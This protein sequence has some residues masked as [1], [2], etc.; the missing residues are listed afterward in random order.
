[1]ANDLE[2][3]FYNNSGRLIHKWKHY[4][5]VYDTYFS[6]F[7]NRE[8]VIVEIGV[9]Q[10]GSLQM[11]KSY[12]GEQASIYGI[13]I[14]PNCKRFEEQNIKIFIGS[15]S[16]RKF[17]RSLKSKIPKIDILI[18]DGGHSMEQQKIAFEELYSHIK[19]KGIYL[20]EDVHTSYWIEFGGGYKRR[21]TFIE[22]SKILI[23]QLNAFHSR[24]SLFKIDEFTKT[25]KA[26]HFYDS[27]VVIEKLDR[28]EPT[29]MKTGLPDTNND[30]TVKKESRLY[31]GFLY[32]I[33]IFL[34]FIGL[35]GYKWK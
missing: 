10:G 2:S 33:N 23:D 20:C 25:M 30:Y 9:Y 27:I 15:Q 17:L 29:H 21:S 4:F 5:E 31:F 18:D 13:D 7:R 35:P 11:W 12:F 3:Y 32:R 26:I 24:Q 19:P 14:N 34:R 8:I 16:D 22:Y 28:T 6:R 1:M